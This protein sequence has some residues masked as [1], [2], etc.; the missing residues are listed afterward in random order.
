MTSEMLRARIEQLCTHITFEYNSKSC[1]VDPFS[2]TSFDMW[3]GDKSINVDSIDKVMNTPLF[4]GKALRDIVD[5][6][7]F[8]NT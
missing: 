8:I 5:K 6:I 4:N 3:Y 2:T 7:D 1:G